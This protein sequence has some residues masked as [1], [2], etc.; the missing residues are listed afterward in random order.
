MASS[1]KNINMPLI[2]AL[3]IGAAVSLVA[4]VMFALAW[5]EYEQRVVLN[6]Q[7]LSL[8]MHDELYD[9]EVAAQNAPHNG[10]AEGH[11]GEGH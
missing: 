8:P 10:H 11:G 5:Y 9:Q 4:T 1:S 2:F 7:V 6:E 3:S